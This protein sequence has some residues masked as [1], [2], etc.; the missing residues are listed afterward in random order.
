MAD[1]E[2]EGKRALQI[3]KPGS[4]ELAV[5]PHAPPYRPPAAGL[6]AVVSSLRYVGKTAGVV[7]GTRAL[8]RLNQVAGFDCPSCAWPDPQH[9]SVAEF[10]ENG[11]RAVGHEADSRKV[12]A[13]FFATH[14]VDE[15]RTKT[16]HWLEDQ[17]RLTT[18]MVLREGATHYA[19]V[20]WDEAFSLIGA[21]LRGLG[22]PNEAAFYTSGRASN[23]AAFTYQLFARAYGTN[24]LPDCSNMCHESTSKGLGT[25]LGIGK[26]TVT[27][28]DFDH[29]DCIFIIGQNPGTNHPRMLTTLGQAAQR[30]A[31]IV[32]INPLRERGL[33]KFANP[34]RVAGMLGVGQQIATH[35]AQV[36]IGGD[37]ALLQGIAKVL[38][39]L[40]DA[41]GGVVDHGFVAKHTYGLEAYRA[42]V[43]GRSWS[44]LEADSGVSERAIRELAEVY[45]QSNA[46][47]ACW[48]M[49]L[50]QHRH[51]VANVCEVVNLMLL[52]GNLGR[53]GAGLCPVRGHSNVQGDRT[54]G[55][56]DAPTEAFLARLDAGTGIVSPRAHGYDAVGTVD[57]MER[58]LVRV[59]VGLG[60]NFTE[61][62][63]DSVRTTAAVRRCDLTVQIATKLNRGHLATGRTA[64]LLPCL[65]RSEVDVR[66]AGPQFV[67][68]EDSMSMVHRSEGRLP[69][70]GPDV[71]SETAIIASIAHA[72][73]GSSPIDF[74]WLADD[75]DRIRD[76]AE[77]SL[78]G[79]T[80]YNERVRLPGGFQ[81]P[82][83]ARELSFHTESER[84]EFTAQE[85]PDLAVGDDR[86][87]LM[88]I[89]SHDQFNTT[90]Y[91][92]D[93]RYRGIHGE[94]EV[95]FLNE[96]D[97]RAR[98]LSDG[99]RVRI[100]SHFRGQKRSVEGFR[101]HTYDIPPGC[102]AAYYPETNP[103]VPLESFADGS[104]TPTSKSIA[105]TLERM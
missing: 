92:L 62:M 40:D 34:Q 55:I 30:G 20:A 58:G 39:E 99:D 49:G 96:G 14:A 43:V 19:P 72:T 83:S 4:T 93:D 33:E 88:T 78:H 8:F 52:R 26:G 97:V 11:A 86:L 41:N 2:R 7:R 105:I 59:F 61:A 47:I 45:A 82:N 23:E 38:F 18:P 17:G 6:P 57:A 10:C 28:E 98:G 77:K 22:S 94:R 36:R 3:A 53:A 66:A 103:L 70:P 73:L 32:A 13:A 21:T 80:R 81:L 48:A 76:L 5:G 75:Y 15:L 104:R 24:N 79:F 42:G 100:V 68:V 29:A 37:V 51:G 50:T 56:H 31:K 12:G 16:G 90:V 54:V 102:A 64:L 44:R 27:L 67:T 74:R 85:L 9:R 91:A 25:V 63:S 84:A 35:H 101:V 71:Q 69:P 60:G 89:R 1:E 95:V 46:T 87:T 65:G